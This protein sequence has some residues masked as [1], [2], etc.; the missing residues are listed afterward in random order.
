MGT[1]GKFRKED[2]ISKVNRELY[3][4]EVIPAVVYGSKTWPLSAQEKR[5]TKVLEIVLQKSERV[6]NS[7]II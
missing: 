3:E 4:R 1:V 6:R 7:L 2:I 5:K